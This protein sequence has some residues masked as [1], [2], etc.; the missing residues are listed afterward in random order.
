MPTETEPI[1]PN[2]AV[3]ADREERIR[4]RAYQLWEKDGVSGRKSGGILASRA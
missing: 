3:D 2:P 4:R 1:P